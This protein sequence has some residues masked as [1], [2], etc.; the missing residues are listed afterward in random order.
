MLQDESVT[1]Q[2]ILISL[3]CGVS[4]KREG[5]CRGELGDVFN[6]NCQRTNITT[7][8]FALWGCGELRLVE[9]NKWVWLWVWRVLS[10]GSADIAARCGNCS[11]VKGVLGE[12]HSGANDVVKNHGKKLCKCGMNT[13]RE[14]GVR[15]ARGGLVRKVGKD[16]E[17]GF[18]EAQ[19]LR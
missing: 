15:N 1:Q 10:V 7:L 11:W 19:D 8:S 4:G 6:N 18:K 14:L 17:R 3:I 13:T 9:Y 2:Q 5:V 12:K 16:G